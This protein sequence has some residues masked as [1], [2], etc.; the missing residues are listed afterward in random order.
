MI[1]IAYGTRPEIIKFFPLIKE[2]EINKI[3]FETLFTGQHP[4]LYKNMKC[5]IPKPDYILNDIMECNQ[6][7]N[8]LS[9]KIL[10]QI[11]DIF[12]LIIR[13]YSKLDYIIVQGDTTTSYIIA[14]SAY[15]R[16]IKIM[17]LEAGLRT[18]NKLSPFPEEGNRQLISRIADIH[19]CPTKLAVKNL[20]NENITE[21]VY[22]VGNTIVDA[23]KYIVSNHSSI[24]NNEIVD[25]KL[26]NSIKSKKYILITLHRRENRGEK[27]INMWKQINELSLE[28]ND[29]VYIYL[30]HP[31]LK[32]VSSYLTND[33][34]ILLEPCNYITMVILINNSCGIITDSGGIQEEAVSANK[35]VLVCRDTTERPETIESGYGLLI[36]DKIKDNIRFLLENS[37]SDNTDS[38]TIDKIDN[39]Y[40]ENVC[41]KIIE[42][43]KNLYL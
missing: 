32:N 26:L 18:N 27:M 24:L 2:F 10:Y 6:T 42:I 8:R 19:F 13:K 34:I 36:D 17:H 31:S 29:I 25:N 7:L 21:N 28:R 5:L 38:N 41:Q 40:G 3:K 12:D 43:I 1:L 30:K 11:D 14:V 20:K 15:Y 23:F 33:K 16:S 39:P 4:D 9:S 35:K 22:N 37:K